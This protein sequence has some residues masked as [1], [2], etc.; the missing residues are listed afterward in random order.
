VVPV[1]VNI[2]AVELWR[3]GFA[4]SVA[5]ILGEAGVPP[6]LLE[7]ELT[8]SRL[9]EDAESSMSVLKSLKCIGVQ[10]VIDDFGTGYSSLSYL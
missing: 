9:M 1:A 10:L 4:D 3:P 6:H 5:C 8:E 7:L 2:S